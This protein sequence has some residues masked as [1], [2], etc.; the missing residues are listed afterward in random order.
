MQ[1]KE[2]KVVQSKNGWHA[3]HWQDWILQ[4]F[5]MVCLIFHT[6][7]IINGKNW[8]ITI[9]LQNFLKSERTHMLEN[10]LHQFV[11]VRFS[12]TSPLTPPQRTYFLNDPKQCLETMNLRTMQQVKQKEFVTVKPFALKSNKTQ[13]AWREITFHQNAHLWSY[14]EFLL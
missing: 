1:R 2:R 14:N 4:S 8:R 10:P 11:F 6:V 12:M 13:N 3:I 9:K 5:M 7:I